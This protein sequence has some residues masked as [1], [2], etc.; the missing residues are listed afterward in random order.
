[1]IT[2]DNYEEYMMMHADGELRPDE[3]QELQAFINAHPQL[4]K[5][6]AAY[7]LTRSTPDTTQ[8]F[9]NKN[10]LL[11]PVPRKYIIAFPQWVKYSV[12]AGIAAIIFISLFK[13]QQIS[14]QNIEPPVAVTTP[15]AQKKEDSTPVA[16]TIAQQTNANQVTPADTTVKPVTAPTV[17]VAAIN[18]ANKQ[19][20]AT[21]E[22]KQPNDT[23]QAPNTALTTIHELP[24]AGTA[25]MPYNNN[26]PVLHDVKDVP[27]YAVKENNEEPEETFWDKLPIEDIKKEQLKSIANTVINVFKDVSA[28]KEDVLEKTISVKIEKRKLRISF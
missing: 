10:S 19:P 22:T 3:E 2:W 18:K 12:A 25:S 13:Y 15:P 4:K 20:V 24:I 17:N 7:E 5:E 14:R 9:T 8:G 6:L 28:A 27:A 26:A 1:M 23:A 16:K 21:H 11:K